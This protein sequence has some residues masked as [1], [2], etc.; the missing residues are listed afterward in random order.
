MT[1][2]ARGWAVFRQC[3]RL[4]VAVD[5]A[6][7]AEIVADFVVA[8]H[9]PAGKNEYFAFPCDMYFVAYQRIGH[10]GVVD[11]VPRRSGVPVVAEASFRRR[12]NP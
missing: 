4:L 5:I 8:A 7:G 10:I 2:A 9:S 12:S 6:E 1:K 11:V 3:E